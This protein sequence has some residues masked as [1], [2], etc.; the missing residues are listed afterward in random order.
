[1]EKTRFSHVTLRNRV[2]IVP[3]L[4]GWSFDLLAVNDMQQHCN[5]PFASQLAAAHRYRL[6][7]CLSLW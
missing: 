2:R 1:L 5:P 6:T 3:V 7:V 4:G